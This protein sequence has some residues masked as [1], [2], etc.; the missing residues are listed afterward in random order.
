M[1][2]EENN[3]DSGEHLIGYIYDVSYWDI[4]KVKD[5]KIPEEA[6]NAK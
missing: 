6:K 1:N 4:N 3:L 5:F 2:E